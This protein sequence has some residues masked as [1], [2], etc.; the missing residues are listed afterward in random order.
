MRA[1]GQVGSLEGPLDDNERRIVAS[2]A[3]LG[4]WI[5]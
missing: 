2:R 4:E 3:I 1:T 5:G